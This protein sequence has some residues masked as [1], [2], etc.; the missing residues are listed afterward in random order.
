VVMLLFM[1]ITESIPSF[2]SF[3]PTLFFIVILSII[4]TQNEREIC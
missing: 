2:Y 1:G 3:E 4:L